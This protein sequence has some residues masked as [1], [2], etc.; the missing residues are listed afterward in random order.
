M[1]EEIFIE[2][3]Q[4]YKAD[5]ALAQRLWIEI[6]EKHGESHRAYHNLSH[7]ENL[8]KELLPLKDQVNNWNIILLGMFYHDAI[9][10]PRKSNNEEKSAELAK[11]RMTELKVPEDQIKKCYQLILA[12]KSHDQSKDDDI[13]LF[14]DADLSILGY[15]WEDYEAYT[16]QIRKEYSIYPNF[17]YKNGRK[18]VLKHF[19]EMD[20]LFK[21]DYFSKKYESQARNNLENELV[22]L[23]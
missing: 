14:T 11:Q 2:L 13:N 8:Y 23:Q 5:Q 1:L 12:T 18:K 20:R 17:L 19:L 22:G 21:T 16:R 3:T 9:Y 10:N 7:L 6:E 15:P 4:F